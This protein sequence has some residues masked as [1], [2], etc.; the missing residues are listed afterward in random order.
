MARSMRPLDSLALLWKVGRWPELTALTWPKT[1]P[2]GR[3]PTALSL[4]SDTLIARRHRKLGVTTMGGGLSGMSSVRARASG[5]VW[6]IEHLRTNDDT[7][8]VDLLTW[9]CEGVLNR[10][11]RRVFLET[12]PEGLGAQV[13]R[14]AGFEAYSSGTMFRLPKGFMDDWTRQNRFRLDGPDESVR[15]VLQD[16]GGNVQSPRPRLRSD[17]AGLFP[18]YSAAVPAQVR[19]AEAMTQEEWA[20]LYPGRKP[21]APRLVSDQDDYVWE[22]GG[23]IVAWMRVVFGQRSQLLEVLIHP[24]YEAY[25]DGMLTSAL[26]QLSTKVPVLADMREYQAGAVSAL[27]RAGFIR[28]DSYTAWV[29][30]LA[31]RVTEPNVGVIPAPASPI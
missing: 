1:D 27:E 15:E 8:A 13:A 5:L 18:P 30:Q 7:S 11:A 31:S 22:M 24:L 10:Q 9:A 17:E 14:Q 2:E 19:W 21:W 23:R 12:A 6:D 25:A 29:R 26:A 28:V 16:A 3:R 20:A 4:L